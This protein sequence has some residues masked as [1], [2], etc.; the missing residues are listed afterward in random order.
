MTET[1]DEIESLKNLRPNWDGFRSPPICRLAIEH[2]RRFVVGLPTDTPEPLVAPVQGGGVYL[3]WNFWNGFI[4]V[5]FD[6]AGAVVL[7]NDQTETLEP[8]DLDEALDRVK[9]IFE[10]MMTS[11]ARDCPPADIPKGRAEQFHQ[12]GIG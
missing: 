7:V 6:A 12:N 1:L 8:E 4:G 5:E 3:G 11:P 10:K 9:K 2:A